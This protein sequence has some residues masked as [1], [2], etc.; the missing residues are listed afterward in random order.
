VTL[1]TPGYQDGG[2]RLVVNGEGVLDL[3]DVF[4]RDVQKAPQDP[5]LGPAPDVPP[6]DGGGLLGPILGDLLG[7]LVLEDDGTQVR[8]SAAQK[9]SS[10]AGTR[11]VEADSPTVKKSVER[12][13]DRQAKI[14]H[15]DGEP[16]GFK[17]IFFRYVLSVLTTQGG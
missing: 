16:I 13:A 4:Y 3:T 11:N 9:G 17:G 10:G 1:N 14:A 6:D 7:E 15:E 2:F 5:D 8:T 12:R